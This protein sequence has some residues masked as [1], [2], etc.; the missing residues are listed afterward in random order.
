MVQRKESKILM[1][2]EYLFQADI[3]FGVQ[4]LL[5]KYL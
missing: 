4:Y 2:G 3:H 1:E 5:P